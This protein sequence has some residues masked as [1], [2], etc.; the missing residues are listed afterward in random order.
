M[1]TFQ[2]ETGRYFLNDD[3]GKLIA[4]VTFQP[5]DDGQNYVIDHTYVDPILRG[6][7]IAGKLVKAVVDL[8]LFD[9][10]KIEPLCSFARHEFETKPEYAEMRRV[11]PTE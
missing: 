3:T 7:G 8:V 2:H 9:G 1:M 4:E 11:A 5:I 6:Q 10:K